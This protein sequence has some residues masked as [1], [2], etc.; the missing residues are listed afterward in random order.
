MTAETLSRT[1]VLRG[2][3]QK[4]LLFNFLKENADTMA[5]QGKPLEVRVTI[6][7]PKATDPQRAL[8]WIINQQ[9][10]DQ[11]WVQ[12]RRFSAECWHEQIKRE[13]LPDETRKGVPKWNFLPNGERELNMSTEDLDREEKTL[14]IEKYLARAAE[15]GVEVHIEDRHH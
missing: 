2:P 10:A 15:L 14:Y 4:R 8:I 1:F 9:V 5:E 7:K 3:D 11:A 13:L 12:G 6:W